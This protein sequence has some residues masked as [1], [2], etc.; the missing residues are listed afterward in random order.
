MSEREDKFRKLAERRVNNA[1]KQLRLVGNLS[2]KNNYG[3]TDEQAKKII[4]TLTNELRELKL[5]FN[6]NTSKKS[7]KFKI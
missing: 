1:I 5:R 7:K 3:Y 2:N 4:N 6:T